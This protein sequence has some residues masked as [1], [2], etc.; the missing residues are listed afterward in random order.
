M[1]MNISEVEHGLDQAS[2]FWK[3]I[4]IKSTLPDAASSLLHGYAGDRLRVGAFCQTPHV[5]TASQ[6]AHAYRSGIMLIRIASGS[7]ALEQ[8]GRVA[9]VAAEDFCIVDLARPF[10]LRYDHT[11]VEAVYLSSAVLQYCPVSLQDAAAIT[12]RGESRRTAYLQAIFTQLF[13]QSEKLTESVAGRLADALPYMLATAVDG[14][15][16]DHQ[17]EGTRLRKHHQDQVRRFARE[18]LA[19][20][21]LSADMI[22]KGVGLSTS[23]VFELFATEPVTLMRWVRQE[24]LTLCRSE[25]A[26]PTLKHGTISALA[27]AWGFGDLTHFSRAFREYFGI[28]PRDYRNQATRSRPPIAM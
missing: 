21:L 26:A 19:D 24:R 10:S 16:F 7:A 25:L 20:P 2:R 4:F 23:Y 12:L 22:A 27:Y 18:H 15:V 3:S 8:N 5:V 28:S 17:T 9:H 13:I 11:I 1:T 6:V 14:W